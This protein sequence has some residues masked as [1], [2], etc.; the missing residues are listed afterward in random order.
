L[1]AEM[2]INLDDFVD[3]LN[4][5]VVEPRLKGVT[6]DYQNQVNQN[7]AERRARNLDQDI[8]DYYDNKGYTKLLKE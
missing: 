7:A 5:D 3:S 6:L 8:K 1:P 2:G 4:E